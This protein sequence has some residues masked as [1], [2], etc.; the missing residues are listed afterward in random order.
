M[1]IHG[2]YSTDLTKD[3]FELDALPNEITTWLKKENMVTEA[4]K[5]KIAQLKE[6]LTD[7]T[8]TT[9]LEILATLHYLCIE[10]YIPNK[11]KTTIEKALIE[12]KPHL[13]GIPLDPYWSK[14]VCHGLIDSTMSKP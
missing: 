8:K 2:P 12:K 7:T 1:Y 3:A 9:D 6:M 11:S 14:L 10:A 4:D 13:T 5:T